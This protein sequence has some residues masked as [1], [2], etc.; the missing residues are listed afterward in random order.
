MRMMMN[1][2][3]I[4]VVMVLMFMSMLMVV[5]MLMGMI[6]VMMTG[7]DRMFLEVGKAVFDG[8]TDP[9]DPVRHTAAVF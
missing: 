6:M 1:M 7:S 8:V 5:I 4:M 9:L 3:M 2:A